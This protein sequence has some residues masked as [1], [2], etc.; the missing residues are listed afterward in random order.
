MPLL[1]RILHD[2][3]VYEQAFGELCEDSPPNQLL[4][5]HNMSKLLGVLLEVSYLAAYSVEVHNPNFL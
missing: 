4:A 1:K 5:N 2:P 3:D